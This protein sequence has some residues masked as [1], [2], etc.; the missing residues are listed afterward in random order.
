MEPKDLTEATKIYKKL[1]IIFFNLLRSAK[2]RAQLK[3][4]KGFKEIS[5][6][7]INN[8]LGLEI[9]YNLKYDYTKIIAQLFVN[10]VSSN[11]RIEKPDLLNLKEVKKNKK[12]FLTKIENEFK[13]LNFK[14]KITKTNFDDLNSKKIIEAINF[15]DDLTSKKFNKVKVEK[16][17]TKNTN[18]SK[19]S[20]NNNSNQNTNY[21]QNAN[22]FNNANQNYANAGNN[23]TPHPLLQ[24]KFYPYTTRPKWIINYKKILGIC[25]I[26]LFIVFF[27]VESILS[28]LFPVSLKD[29][30][31]DST[32]G[33]VTFSK[34]TAKPLQISMMAFGGF[35]LLIAAGL[36]LGYFGFDLLGKKRFKRDHYYTQPIAL[37]VMLIFIIYIGF[38]ILFS[39][40]PSLL[41]F[42]LKKSLKFSGKFPSG[43]YY[44]NIV[45]SSTY[46]MWQIVYSIFLVAFVV[47]AGGIV[48]LII[49]NPRL[50]REKIARANAEYA[51]LI[52]AKFNKQDY[53]MDPSLF[54]D[55]NEN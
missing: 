14:E 54:D 37:W 26:T 33:I 43:G 52:Q 40:I 50:D 49:K 35:F 10:I 20:S 51:K 5:F 7:N 39:I 19:A 32:S 16:K 18:Y 41:N 27:L 24:E 22:F 1:I 25:V 6:Q 36:I 44:N 46:L 45:Q 11:E 28:Y 55:Y 2:L 48:Y 15:D 21:S 31:Y 34:G 4:D 38:S 13:N 47:A 30:T 8:L 42:E 3:F 23:V 53:E 17:Q 9:D 29:F 12:S